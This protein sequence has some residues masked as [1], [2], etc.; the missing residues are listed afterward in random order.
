[1]R[2]KLVFFGLAI[3]LT[4][5]QVEANRPSC[6]GRILCAIQK[7]CVND[8]RSSWKT[9]SPHFSDAWCKAKGFDLISDE[10]ERARYRV[11]IGSDG[12]VSRGGVALEEGEYMYVMYQNGEF[13]LHPERQEPTD[14]FHHTSFFA[15]KPVAGSGTMAIGRRLNK[16]TNFSGSLRGDDR[17]LKQTVRWLSGMMDVS[18]LQ[19]V[20]RLPSGEWLLDYPSQTKDYEMPAPQ[21]LKWH[22]PRTSILSAFFE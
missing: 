20:C 4:G 9:I 5:S 6:V 11:N 1:M 21:F 17:S 7:C 18:D 13:Y 10:T 14:S 15:N 3:L 19:V 16:I 8:Q 22:S 12:T 2:R